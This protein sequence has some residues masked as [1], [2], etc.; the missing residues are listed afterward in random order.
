[1][2]NNSNY[3]LPVKAIPQVTR[4]LPR[5]LPVAAAAPL[6]AALSARQHSLTRC[7]PLRGVSGAMCDEKRTKTFSN[8]HGRN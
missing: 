8:C 6:C 7:A 3:K 1:M 5:D 2:I 4:D